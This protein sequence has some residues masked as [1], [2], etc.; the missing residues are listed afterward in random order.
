[1]EE[2]KE[3]LKSFIHLHSN[4]NFNVLYSESK[5]LY[6]FLLN[7]PQ[8]I[9]FI[10]HETQRPFVPFGYLG[11]HTLT[12]RF[13]SSS[14]LN[15]IISLKGI[16]TSVSVN[17]FKLL[18]SVHYDLKNNL[19]YA[20][21]YRDK[22]MISDMPITLKIP[23]EVNNE[24]VEVQYGMSS[25]T[26]CCV[27]TLQEMPEECV[28]GMMPRSV[29]VI[30]SGCKNKPGDR[31]MVIGVYKSVM[32]ESIG[33]FPSRFKAVL[34]SYNIE[35][36][37]KNEL[38]YNECIK[39]ETLNNQEINIDKNNQESNI[40]LKYSNNKNNKISFENELNFI[41]KNVSNDFLHHFNY[42]KGLQNHLE[43]LSSFI[44]PSVFGHSTIKKA[45]LLM[46]LSGTEKIFENKSK[47]RSSI[48]ILLIGDPSTAKSQILRFISNFTNCIS[49]T[50]R[51]SSGVGLT[52]CISQ[53]KE[54]GEKR[55]EAGAMVLSDLN[56]LCIDEFDKMD[57]NDRLSLHEAMEQ[58]TVSIN[59][60][61]INATLN[62]RCSVLAAA[63]PIFGNYIRK[64]SVDKN[65]GLPVSL[66][67]RF[68]C[69]FVCLDLC[70]ENVDKRIAE[71]V[72]ENHSD[73][74]FNSKRENN[75]KENKGEN[76]KDNNRERGDKENN[77]G[78]ENKVDKKNIKQ[79]NKENTGIKGESEL[80][81]EKN[82]RKQELNKSEEKENFSSDSDENNLFPNIKNIKYL[83]NYINIC[84]NLKPFLTKEAQDL[85]IKYYTDLRQKTNL[86]CRITPRT[87]ETI[88]RMSCACA[89]LRFSDQV[90]ENDVYSV[91]EILNES[92]FFDKEKTEISKKIKIEDSFK[93][94]LDKVTDALFLCREMNDSA[95]LSLNDF[96]VHV[97]MEK[98]TVKN[99]LKYLDEE[100]IIIYG[101]ELITFIN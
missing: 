11:S 40:D 94:N 31:I 69:V 30:V 91:I 38:N 50:G 8:L 86:I 7:N 9:P 64:L 60:A 73:N 67:T 12:P 6:T 62:A 37:L 99:V 19:F 76:N 56:T 29:E 65:I 16:I 5:P 71:R 53:D 57:E 101:D 87:I 39:S 61:G 58:Q 84:K 26:D 44:A 10:E 82:I 41:E 72:M 46:L 81:E 1:M 79:N 49:T 80:V 21:V 24:K 36:I 54:T 75:K 4:F 27:V 98:E 32:C 93:E 59:K 17:K 77:I 45:I 66:L 89:K 90:L 2:N 47:I 88:L 51:G 25:F 34:I 23:S 28:P 68:D 48:N 83:K 95:F 92:L 18:Q 96:L 15:K 70:D 100:E 52:A 43:I 63:N 42:F 33:S 85:I 78:G 97:D 35:N 22:Y 20:K 74:R 3:L 14:F 55:L 13:L